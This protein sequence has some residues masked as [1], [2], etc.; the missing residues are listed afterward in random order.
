VE[1]IRI[2]KA[3]E[4]VADELR[5]RIVTGSLQA[6]DQLPPEGQLVEQFQV[7]RTSVREALRILESEGLLAIRRGPAGGGQVRDPDPRTL[8][9]YASLLLQLE[10]A[11]V[12]DVHRARI[13]IEPPAAVSLAQRPDR[14]ALAEQLSEALGAEEASK[15]HPEELA[16]MEGRFHQLVTTLTGNETLTLLSSVSNLIVAHHVQRFFENRRR[17]RA[18]VG[19]GFE[20][21]HRA[22]ARL[23]EL[24]ASGDGSAVELLWR[25]HLE[26]AFASLG[27]LSKMSVL[28]LMS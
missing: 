18:D 11:T 26:E 15:Q 8:A 20:A 27:P 22:H 19:A 16:K 25:R 3:A 4:L 5:R 10:G 7:A 21:A 17:T 24:V 13:M 12:E 9:R 28:D 23:V 14:V 2:P 6:G 1:A